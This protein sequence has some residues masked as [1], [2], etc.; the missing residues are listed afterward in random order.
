MALP[1]SGGVEDC[2]GEGEGGASGGSR[3][4][5]S[6]G[7]FGAGSLRRLFSGKDSVVGPALALMLGAEG[8]L[9]TKAALEDG[10]GEDREPAKEAA[11]AAA[12]P[13]EACRCEAARRALTSIDAF[14]GEVTEKE[15]LARWN[16]ATLEEAA[17]PS[18]GEKDPVAC[19]DEPY[20]DDGGPPSG[21]PATGDS[22]SSPE[23]PS[24]LPPRIISWWKWWSCSAPLARRLRALLPTGG[25]PPRRALGIRRSAAMAA[26]VPL[27][28]GRT[29]E[30]LTLHSD[31]RVLLRGGEEDELCGEGDGWR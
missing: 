9:P 10:S 6:G 17:P 18:R 7:G 25:S 5:G 11:A 26:A 21:E 22:P 28:V 31:S 29:L 20:R 13:N 23:S 14:L 4:E 27:M 19:S 1:P 30:R 3:A 24:W 15:L 2:S 8:G 16:D 12:V